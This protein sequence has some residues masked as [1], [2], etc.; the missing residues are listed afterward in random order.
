MNK[1]IYKNY[2]YYLRYII[3]NYYTP[4]NYSRGIVFVHRQ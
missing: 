2:N 3:I 4:N 1:L